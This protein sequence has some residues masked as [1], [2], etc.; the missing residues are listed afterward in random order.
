MIIFHITI[1]YISHLPRVEPH[2]VRRGG[3]R[4]AFDIGRQEA[5]WHGGFATETVEPV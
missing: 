3:R 1:N 4:A 2:R 5:L